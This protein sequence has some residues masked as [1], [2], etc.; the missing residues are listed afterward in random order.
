VLALIAGTWVRLTNCSTG[1][2]ELTAAGLSLA[3]VKRSLIFF[4]FAAARCV[5][6]QSASEFAETA[7][8]DI[9]AARWAA[10][11]Q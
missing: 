10:L 5:S 8:K 11:A 2:A 9:A 1:D 6:N 4:F 7:L 3:A